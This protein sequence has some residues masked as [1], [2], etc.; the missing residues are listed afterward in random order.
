MVA[1][2]SV[3][4]FFVYKGLGGSETELESLGKLLGTGYSKGSPK[5]YNF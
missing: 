1:N 2:R 5:S 3:E 4:L